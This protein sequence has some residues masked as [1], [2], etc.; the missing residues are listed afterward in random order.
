M[1]RRTFL[2]R[3]GLVGG[4]LAASTAIPG[5]R[6]L[7]PPGFEPGQSLLDGLASDCPVDTVVVLMMENRS[8]DHWLGWL[9]SDQQY[10]EAGRS[11][12]GALFGVD[13]NQH[14][15]YAGP[16][17]PVD[18]RY[19]F[20]WDQITNPWRGCDF[21][22]PGHSW[23]TGRVQRD[24]GFLA[25]GSGNDEFALGY[26]NAPDLAFSA[27]L[28]KRFTT[29]DSYHCSVLGPTNPNREY[30]HS[31]QSGGVKSNYLPI[32]EG[33]FSWP[34]IWDRL[35][36]AG[37]PARYY[38]SDL[39]VTFLWGERLNPFNRPIAEFY[40]DCAAGTLPNV[41]FLDPSFVGENRTDDHPLADVRAGQGFMRD[42]FQAF[43]QSPQWERGVFLVTYD[44][45]GG[46]FDHVAPPHLADDR[47]STNDQDDFSQA[48][49]RVPTVM[50]SPFARPG[51]VDRRVYD[52][53]SILR[54]LE[55]RFLGAPPEG[56]GG[57]GAGWFLT[58]RDQHANNIGASLMAQPFSPD[59][60]FDP[61]ALDVGQVSTLCAGG[62][63]GGLS[64]ARGAPGAADQA[65]DEAQWAVYLDRL[66]V[67]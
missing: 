47:T 28:T 2:K 30:L 15:T 16:D 42:V 5:C 13:G 22:D 10:L 44:E 34:T 9:A 55:W 20:A 17:G 21:G 29:F 53:T 41:V 38:Y 4:A 27:R 65:F 45:W 8:F 58:Q 26:Y 61:A 6:W 64:A 49:F 43:A 63:T 66:G 48:G 19:L 52:H 37:V 23:T 7:Y 18:T 14:Q 67:A 1:D 24:Q 39:P 56:P 32:A 51:F 59:L 31:A 40:A 33:G 46:F 11:R 3:A 25:P 57:P 50:A 12:Y 60:W 62:T 36:A 54:F 35:G